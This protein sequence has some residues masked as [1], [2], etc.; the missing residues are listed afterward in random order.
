MQKKKQSDEPWD[1]DR[2]M[3]GDPITQHKNNCT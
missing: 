2:K 3:I 1:S